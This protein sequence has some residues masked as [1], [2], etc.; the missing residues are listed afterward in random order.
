VQ[1][2]QV[3]ATAFRP[4]WLVQSR[5]LSLF[6]AGRIDRNALDAA[7]IWRS[8]AETITPTRVQS[9]DVR[10]DAPLAPNDTPMMRRVRAAA[11]LREAAAA[12]G[13]LRVAILDAV[14][15]RD[16]PWVGLGR[17]LRVSDKTA[18]H[19]AA[20]AIAALAAWRNG[21]TVLPPP[22]IRFRNEPGRL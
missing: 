20:E 7:C 12:L 17:S 10:V 3:D 1:A 13:Q 15:V 18:R 9:W 8:W 6:E 2:P 4:G 16:R 14:V 21:E 11:K 22:A 19:Y 5:L